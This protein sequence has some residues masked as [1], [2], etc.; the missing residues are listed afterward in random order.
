M[1]D[2]MYV[3]VE[4]EQFA[5]WAAIMKDTADELPEYKEYAEGMMRV[6]DDAGYGD[7]EG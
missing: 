7:G 1:K 6:L 3:F 4:V 2:G 5:L